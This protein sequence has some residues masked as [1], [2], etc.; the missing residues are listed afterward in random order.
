MIESFAA[1]ALLQKTDLIEQKILLLNIKVKHFN[2]SSVVHVDLL[3]KVNLLSRPAGPAP[4]GAKACIKQRF[5]NTTIS[6][7]HQNS[8][9]SSP[10]AM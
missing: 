1:K 3:E 9:I 4:A 8:C 10:R 5:K 2:A 6:A 7:C